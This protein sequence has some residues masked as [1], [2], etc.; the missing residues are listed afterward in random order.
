MATICDAH[1]CSAE[2]FP[3]HQGC[4][5]SGRDYGPDSYLAGTISFY[6]KRM[7]RL[8]SIYTEFYAVKIQI[9]ADVDVRVMLTFLELYQTLLSFVFFKLYT[10]AELV[11]PPPLDTKKDEGGAG[12]NAMSLQD[13]SL[14]P[15][16]PAKTVS[17]DD[18][19]I[20]GKDVRQ[21]IKTINASM[22]TDPIETEASLLEPKSSEVEEDFVADPSLSNNVVSL[23]LPT[24][25]SLAAL[26][27]TLSTS[28]FSPFTFFLSRETSRSI[29]EFAV[30]CFGGRIGWPASS[31]MGSPFD[32][33]DP[34]ITH[35]IIDRPITELD[36]TPSQRDLRMRR[37]YVQPQWIV[38]CINAGKI[39]IEEPYAQGKALP[40]HLSPFGEYEGAYIPGDLGAKDESI[41]DEGV[42]EEGSEMSD[43]VSST[44][45][46][47]EALD[48]TLAIA[49]QD[50]AALRAAELAA[51]A[52]GVDYGTFEEKLKKYGKK[53]S[54][55]PT[56]DRDEVAEKDMNKM[57][58]SNKQKKLYE[59]MKYSQLKKETEVSRGYIIYILTRL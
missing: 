48:V 19:Q 25:Q 46:Q 8:S 5:L 23:E 15:F 52:S 43:K 31:G 35:V 50:V 16:P 51:E 39:L 3:I 47:V 10:D 56:G 49:A 12:L 40:P 29:F 32:E 17:V 58:M 54:K 27:H 59:K 20:S 4:L 30:R 1:A 44:G 21:T 26:P 14:P 24:L 55:K 33:S 36:E 34:T 22:D 53:L 7:L 37:K 45:K 13:I 6:S 57:M 9:P 42:D 11:Y 2:N 38:D 28:L 18:H 41:S